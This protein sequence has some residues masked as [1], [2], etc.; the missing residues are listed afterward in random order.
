M[1]NIEQIYDWLETYSFSELS[2]QQRKVVLQEITEQEYSEMRKTLGGTKSYFEKAAVE[3]GSGKKNSLF[4]YKIELYKVAIAACLIVSIQ[5]VLNFSKS[6]Q[7]DNLL[8]YSDTVYV[9]RVDT[10][11]EYVFDTVEK[12][13]E[14]LV[15]IDKQKDGSKGAI[16]ALEPILVDPESCEKQLCPSDLAEMEAKPNKNSLAADAALKEFVVMLE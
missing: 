6:E 3:T 15:Y 16:P 8:A 14:V 4:S 13:K 7:T 9:D 5:L 10:V 2:E 11:L 1:K 12:T